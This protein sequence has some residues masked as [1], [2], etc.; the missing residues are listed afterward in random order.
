MKLVEQNAE[1]G[2]IVGRFQSP[3]LHDGYLEV[4]NAVKAAHPRVI[5]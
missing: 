1:V 4:I 3:S 5:I 2:V